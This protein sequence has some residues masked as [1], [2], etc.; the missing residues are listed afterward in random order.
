MDKSVFLS[1]GQAGFS[2]SKS[3]GFTL[4]ELM[5]VLAI[6]GILSSIAVPMVLTVQR[7]SRDSERVK[8]LD[9]VRVAASQ[10]YTRYGADIDV[11][12]SSNCL[13]STLVSA[14]ES[15]TSDTN[16]YYICAS[17]NP[18]SRRVI[19]VTLTSGFFLKR[20]SANSCPERSTGKQI[21]FYIDRGSTGSQGF[22]VLC[23]ESGG[24]ERMEYKQD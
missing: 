11:Y 1:N 20:S 4:L 3:F 9:A 5:V 13:A 23:R 2:K 10:F 14:S 16:T 21:I 22:F 15:S 7:N 24:E 17:A 8:Q 19:E 18:S 12:K 6:I